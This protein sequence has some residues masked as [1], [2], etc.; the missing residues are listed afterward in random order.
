[1]ILRPFILWICSITLLHAEEHGSLL[2]FTNG[3]Q[4]HG[5]FQGMKSG[6]ELSWLRSDLPAPVDFKTSQ[7]RHIILAQDDAFTP[8]KTLSHISLVQGDRIPGTIIKMDD[9]AITLDTSYAGTLQIP[10]DQVTMIAPSPLGGRSYYH[11]PFLADEWLMVHPSFP[12]GLPIEKPAKEDDQKLLESVGRWAFSGSA[13]Y[14]ADKNI[15][16]ALVKKDSMPE[17]S[18]LRFEVAWKSRLALAIGI[19]ADF[20]KPK[21]NEDEAKNNQPAGF[22]IH[23]A[24][25]SFLP[26][27][28]GNSYVIQIFSTHLVLLRSSINEQGAP[29]TERMQITSNNLRL[30]ESGKTQL[31]IRSNRQTGHISL[32][33]NGELVFQWNESS[34]EKNKDA[35]NKSMGFGFSVQSSDSS[36]KISDI[37]LAEW[38]GMPDSAR[39]MQVDEQDIVLLTNGTDR[40]S[41]TIRSLENGKLLLDGKYGQFHL[42]LDDIAE[43]RFARNRITKQSNAEP[44]TETSII[45]FRPIGQISGNILNANASSIRLKSP[46]Y[47]EMDVKLQSATMLDFKP[48][49]SIIDDWDAEF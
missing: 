12:D 15:G 17:R 14:W 20:T 4:L 29:V 13:W 36:V 7:L 1:M 39:S 43:V 6:S 22:R 37:T 10:R 46:I 35:S 47:G 42:Q 44:S 9:K 45:R 21:P 41:G 5:K 25:S 31:E 38:N 49:N 8:L 2:R 27:L 16:T 33:N 3:D 18:V 40:F 48:S 23:S 28:F 30:S 32:F 34:N 26:R 11:G 24:D 19:H